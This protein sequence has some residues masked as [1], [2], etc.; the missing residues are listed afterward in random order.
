[1][2]IER[3]FI[4]D[5]S[6]VLYLPLYKLDG[7]SFMSQDA[8]GHLCTVTGALWGSNGRSFD[9]LDDKIVV[10]DHSSLDPTS[11]ITVAAW[12]KVNTLDTT[13]FIVSKRDPPNKLGY[14]FFFYESNQ[15]CLQGGD[16]TTWAIWNAPTD[17]TYG[18]GW[19]FVVG[20]NDAT[21]CLI[22]VDGVLAGSASGGGMV[23]SS[24]DLWVGRDVYSV[25]YTWDT[26]I[27]E[28]CIYGRELNPM[29]I[30]LHY[31]AT[32]WRYQ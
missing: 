30:Q 21:N 9:G 6:L 3:D 29:E 28:V 4:F 27:G 13:Q 31:L 10:P 23:A 8:Y 16:G 20:T 22:Y 26:N 32:K 24:A 1:M 15:F 25:D 17:D 14:C 19:Y 18:P 12:V 11:A 7:A 2:E 5:P